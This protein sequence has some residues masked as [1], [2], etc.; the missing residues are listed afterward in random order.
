M[1]PVN[2][3]NTKII[4]SLTNI[5]KIFLNLMYLFLILYGLFLRFILHSANKKYFKTVIVVDFMQGVIELLSLGST[6]IMTY[7]HQIEW[8]VFLNYFQK[9]SKNVFCIRIG[10]S[11]FAIFGTAV[12]NCYQ[13]INIRLQIGY[14]FI[15]H[16]SYYI[17]IIFHLFL[18]TFL[19][20]KGHILIKHQEKI[21]THLKHTKMYFLNENICY[22][23]TP[24]SYIK[25]SSDM[26]QI[27]NEFTNVCVNIKNLNLLYGWQMLCIFLGGIVNVLFYINYTIFIRNSDDVIIVTD[28][29]R[30]V[31]CVVS[32]SSIIKIFV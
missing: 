29:L 28:S 20:L 23:F 7:R 6:F 19:S 25:F 26:K 10:I 17:C 18:G 21:L 14:F 27:T 13:L 1:V 12:I 24:K 5:F 15:G 32:K 11:I 9:Y 30:I 16:Y 4:K 8:K 3:F 2:V 31:F 22:I